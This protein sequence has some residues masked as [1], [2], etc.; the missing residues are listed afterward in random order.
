MYAYI[1]IYVP[2]KMHVHSSVYACFCIYKHTHSL[3]LPHTH[4]HADARTYTHTHTPSLSPTH[5][6]TQIHTQTHT[7]TRTLTHT[8]ALSHTLTRTHI[9]YN[10]ACLQTK[11]IQFYYKIKTK[12]FK[13]LNRKPKSAATL[14][15][16]VV[17]TDTLVLPK[18]RSSGWV[19]TNWLPFF[20]RNLTP[21]ISGIPL[22]FFFQ[23]VF[24]FL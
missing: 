8:N 11:Y 3:S 19:M 6:N 17:S 24:F 12:T 15:Q 20:V 23:P 1:H 9:S 21:N 13:L 14:M 5:P 10:P 22:V 2:V 16:H 4:K 18:N 7:R